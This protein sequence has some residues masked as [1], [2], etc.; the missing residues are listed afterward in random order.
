MGALSSYHS[1]CH[2][3]VQVIFE[4][5]LSGDNSIETLRSL[6][7]AGTTSFFAKPVNVGRLI[8]FLSESLKRK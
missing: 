6:P 8:E 3:I 4:R 2:R 1:I 5:T 7:D